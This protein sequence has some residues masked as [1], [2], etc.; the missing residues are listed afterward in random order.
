MTSLHEERMSRADAKAEPA[1]YF[2]YVLEYPDGTF[3]VGHTNAPLA[4]WT[5]HAVGI[6]ADATAGRG[7]F[8]VRVAMPFLSRK[9]AQYNEERLQDALR[10]GRL[11]DLI[12]VYHQMLNVVR[13]EK[14][15]R[16]LEEE[17][18]ERDRVANR[19]YHLLTLK[20][21]DAFLSA[22]CGFARGP[23]PFGRWT[24]AV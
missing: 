9:E 20:R 24:H 8:T 2:S 12:A 18:A 19:S 7:E 21:G 17:Q 5:E 1:F 22:V 14:T 11:K 10:I 23:T 3:Y 6:G 4:R 16:E 13:P 15:L